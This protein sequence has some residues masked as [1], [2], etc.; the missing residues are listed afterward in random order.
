MK[1]KL[2]KME[3]LVASLGVTAEIAQDIAVDTLDTFNAGLL[4]AVDNKETVI[5]GAITAYAVNDMINN[6]AGIG[7]TLVAVIAGGKTLKGAEKM[8]KDFAKNKEKVKQMAK[9]IIDN[10]D[11]E[12]DEDEE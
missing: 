9:E 10:L 11:L 5:A 4:T 1:N 12:E 7:N 2:F 6:G 8:K 3:E